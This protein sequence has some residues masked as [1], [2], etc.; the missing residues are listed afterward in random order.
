MKITGRAWVFL[1]VVV[2]D[3]DEVEERAIAAWI[4]Q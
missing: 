2:E 3:A 1:V 4:Q